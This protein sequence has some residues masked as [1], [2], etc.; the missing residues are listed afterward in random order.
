MRQK[1]INIDFLLAGCDFVAKQAISTP[2]GQ[3]IAD[4][5]PLL[6]EDLMV[7]LIETGAMSINGERVSEEQ[8]LDVDTRIVILKKLINDPKE[9]RRR[10][11]KLAPIKKVNK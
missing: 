11:A 5:I 6:N 8:I 2:P 9:L 1:N 4:V 10:R 7:A 3:K